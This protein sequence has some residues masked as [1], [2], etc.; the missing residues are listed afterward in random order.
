MS[1]QADVVVP[2]EKVLTREE[3]I[4]NALANLSPEELAAIYPPMTR[5]NFVVRE[6]WVGRNQKITFTNKKGQT[7][8]YD[9]D[10]AL[11]LMLPKLKLSPNWLKRK[12]WSQSTNLPSIVQNSKAIIEIVEPTKEEITEVEQEATEK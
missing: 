9:H 10:I 11:E 4:A 8:T 12:Y 3:L 7:I 2:T 1:N 5:K 6:S